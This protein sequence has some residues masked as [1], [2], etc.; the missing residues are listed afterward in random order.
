MVPDGL[1]PDPWA[2]E[3]FLAY[4]A[5]LVVHHPKVVDDGALI[6]SSAAPGAVGDPTKV[7]RCVGVVYA[8]QPLYLWGLQ[9]RHH[10]EES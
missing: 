1:Q 7:A 8:H 6:L 5:Q 10:V 3:A 4:E 9:G 2:A